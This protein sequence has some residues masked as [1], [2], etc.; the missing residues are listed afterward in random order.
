MTGPVPA[1]TTRARRDRLRG[2]LRTAGL[3]ALLLTDLINLRYLTGFT[4][5]NAALLVVA[6]DAEEVEGTTDIE[7][8]TDG[9][10]TKGTTA[11]DA[12]R[13]RT[14]FCTDGRYTTQSAAEVPDLPRLIGRPCDRALLALA[15]GG[16]VGFEARSLSVADH[17]DLTAAARDA[18]AKPKLTATVGLV[19][20]LRAVKD[21]AEIDALR[22]ACEVADRAL[23]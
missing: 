2:L 23:A 7:D 11:D 17:T 8:I 20:Q 3:D 10:A 14:R 19:E 13:T 9:P 6:D 16:V 15:P 4:G 22:R 5:S 12:G 18:A 21:V 1:S